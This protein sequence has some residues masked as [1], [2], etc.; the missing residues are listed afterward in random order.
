VSVREVAA[1]ALRP[2]DILP[3]EDQRGPATVLHV[4]P[5]GSSR[6]DVLITWKTDTGIETKHRYRAQVK[7]HVL[8]SDPMPAS[9]ARH[10]SFLK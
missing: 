3:T 5:S 7:V 4:T 8:R 1:G 9:I 2:G 10:L 6:Q